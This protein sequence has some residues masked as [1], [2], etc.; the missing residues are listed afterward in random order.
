MDILQLSSQQGTLFVMILAGV[1][2]ARKGIID[3]AGQ[4][5]LTDL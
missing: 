1:V 4:R 2:L 3:D 5:C